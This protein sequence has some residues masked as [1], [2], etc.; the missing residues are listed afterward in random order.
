MDFMGEKQARS[1]EALNILYNQAD[2][3][4]GIGERAQMLVGCSNMLQHLRHKNNI[5]R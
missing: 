2:N 3:L 5:A 4:M 1:A